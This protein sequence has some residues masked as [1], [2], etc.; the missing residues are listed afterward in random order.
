MKHE[1]GDNMEKRLLQLQVLCS[2]FI[3]PFRTIK[4]V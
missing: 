1:L 4:G 3:L 2:A